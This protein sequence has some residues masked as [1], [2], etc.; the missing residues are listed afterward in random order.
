[1]ISTTPRNG[2]GGPELLLIITGARG[3]GETVM[4]GVAQ[5]LAHVH[6][7]GIISE[8]ATV[9]L[10]GRLGES[11][12]RLAEDRF[13]VSLSGAWQDTGTALLR[14]FQASG[15]GLVITV[16]EIH[17]R[18]RDE[19]AKIGAAI[20]SFVDEGLPAPW[21]WRGCLMQ[22]PSFWTTRHRIPA[23]SRTVRPPQCD[24]EGRREVPQQT[25]TA[26]GFD[27]P[28]PSAKQRTPLAVIHT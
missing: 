11:M 3:V 5:D 20:Q 21:S 18:D 12:R 28:V 22:C 17:A 6:S 19:G 26:G 2:L 8:T 16:D 1:M 15:A 27:A 10:A 7:W 24:S 25:L 13:G 23:A 14:R 4:L 9:G